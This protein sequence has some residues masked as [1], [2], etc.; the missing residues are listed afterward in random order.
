[1]ITNLIRFLHLFR[2]IL[3]I[4]PQH[5]PELEAPHARQQFFCAQFQRV[6]FVSSTQ[7]LS[8]SPWL[9]NDA[10]PSTSAIRLRH[11]M[12]FFSPK[13]APDAYNKEQNRCLQLQYRLYRLSARSFPGIK[14]NKTDYTS[15]SSSARLNRNLNGF[16]ARSAS[17]KYIISNP[18]FFIQWRISGQ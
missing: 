14:Y 5:H 10:F 6:S 9:L 3:A 4:V 11:T 15:Y 1:M 13:I 17:A 12:P 8:C 7:L 2:Y 16:R 18:A